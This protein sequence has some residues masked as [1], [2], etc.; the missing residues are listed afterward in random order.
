MPK[1]QGPLSRS[2]PAR[3]SQAANQASK[4]KADALKAAKKKA[5]IRAEKN[6]PFK[7]KHS[8][9]KKATKKRSG[10]LPARNYGQMS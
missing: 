1:K 4:K 3:G 9:K 10:M 6:T 7:P 5:Q 2:K 8:S